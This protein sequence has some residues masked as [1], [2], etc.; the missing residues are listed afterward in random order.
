MIK[1]A[2]T[3]AITETSF[4]TLINIP[5]NYVLL[6]LALHWE[7]TLM[8]T[9]LLCTGAFFAIAIVRKTMFRMYFHKKYGS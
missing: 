2:L 6:A 7:F 8:Q 9:T 1:Q 4:A 5:I 3:E